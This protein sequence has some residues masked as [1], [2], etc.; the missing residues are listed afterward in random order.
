MKIPETTAAVVTKSAR[1]GRLPTWQVT[2]V[3]SKE[4]EEVIEKAQKEVRTVH[5]A[6][7]TDI[8]LV[9]CFELEKV[10]NQQKSC[11]SEVL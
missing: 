3:K 11:G 5:F 4:E 1:L 2:K 10:S 7:K 9:K 6:K 8:R